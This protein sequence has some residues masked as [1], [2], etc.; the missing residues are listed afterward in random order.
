MIVYP[1]IGMALVGGIHVK[2]ASPSPASPR[3]PVGAGGVP[4]VNLSA[5]V[6][7]LVPPAVVTVTST[8]PDPGGLVAVIWVALETAKVPAAAVPNLTALAPP[9]LVPVS[10]TVVPPALGPLFG[11]NDVTAGA[12]GDVAPSAQMAGSRAH[13]GPP[14]QSLPRNMTV[15]VPAGIG[16]Q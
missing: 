16:D 7:E 14:H 6:T 9:K 15:C 11:V 13:Q 12:A 5:A 2:V 4:Y 8:V 10:V 1:V 3:R